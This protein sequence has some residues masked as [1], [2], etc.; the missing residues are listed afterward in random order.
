M[1]KEEATMEDIYEIVRQTVS[2]QYRNVS[3]FG[4][5]QEDI[6]QDVM[7]KVI[8]N[9]DRFQGDCKVSSW[10]YRIVNNTII[11]IAIKHGREKRKAIAE[12]SI[13]SNEL[14]FEDENYGD[15]EEN[16]LHDERIM[17]VNDYIKEHYSEER[18]KVFQGV[19]RGYSNTKI[20]DVYDIKYYKVLEHVGAIKKLR[21]DY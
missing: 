19:L 21:M 5:E 6:V 1:T 10:V 9:W 15:F 16:L 17:M 12:Y 20:G 7:I 18:Q 4:E 11:N 2:R 3:R 8:R 14:E 13:E